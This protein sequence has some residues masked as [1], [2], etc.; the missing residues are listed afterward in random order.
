MAKQTLRRRITTTGLAARNP[1]TEL[2]KI[3]EQQERPN[4]QTAIFFFFA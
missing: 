3:T 1:N 2:T 4:T